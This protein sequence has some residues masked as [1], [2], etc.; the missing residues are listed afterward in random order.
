ML[1]IILFY[2]KI[3]CPQY[4]GRYYFPSY[5][6]II[7][8]KLEK[9]AFIYSYLFPSQSSFLFVDAIF[10]LVLHCPAW[11]AYFNT[12]SSTQLLIKNFLRFC[13]PSFLIDFLNGYKIFIS[14][15]YYKD[16]P[17]LPSSFQQFCQEVSVLIFVPLYVD[18]LSLWL[19]SS[20]SLCLW[21]SSVWLWY[22]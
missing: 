11:K 13:L 3:S 9:K 14:L 8:L 2:L 20:Y 6:Y 4:I 15:Q 7:K 16:F 19:S 5:K 18:F 12:S 10:Q 1:Y 22:I 17:S 21:F